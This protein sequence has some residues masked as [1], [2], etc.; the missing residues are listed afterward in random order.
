MFLQKK[1][2][3]ANQFIC[4]MLLSFVVMAAQGIIPAI[5]V[6]LG[7]AVGLLPSLVFQN[8]VFKQSKKNSP[9]KMV[10]KFY[11]A[12]TFKFILLIALFFCCAQWP[13][14]KTNMFFFSFVFMQAT[15]WGGN[16]LRLRTGAYN[17][18]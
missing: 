15:S 9:S 16:L 10:N 6:G 7:A 12:A 1:N 17:E 13:P 5:S 3:I 14:L 18:R 2:I 11:W 4:A 8:L